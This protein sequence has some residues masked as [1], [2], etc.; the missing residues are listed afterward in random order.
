MSKRI[1]NLITKELQKK[2]EGSD[3]VVVVDYTGIN[4]TNTNA[5][6]GALRQKK[7]KFTVVRN[8]MAARALEAVG[9][10]G[11]GE[12][13]KGTNAVVYGGESIVDLVK[14]LVE[15]KKKIE[16]LT[17]KGSIVEGKILDA[18]TTVAL[19]KMPNKK[20]L[21]SIIVGQ[22]LS[23]G[24]KIAGQLKGPGAKIAAQ[25]K[26]IEE[27]AEKAAEKAAKEAPVA[28]VAEAAPEAPAAPSA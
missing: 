26:T 5:V 21:K 3:C 17:I 13:L 22:I 2:F 15:Q 14:E 19:S 27:N 24:S 8:A 28:A 9:L 20:E 1:K 10:K 25:L 4:A 7:A 16:K 18:L 6:R 11:A 12:L 23:P